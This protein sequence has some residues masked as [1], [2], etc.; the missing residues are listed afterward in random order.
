MNG[1]EQLLAAYLRLQP[2][3]VAR[4]LEA[5]PVEQANAV[6]DRVGVEIAAP[7]LGAMLPTSAARCVE[8]QPSADGARLLQRLGSQE[9]AAVLRHLAATA[10][11]A[12]LDS[13][14]PQWVVA[15][16]LLLSYP[17]N[18]VG[19]WVEP[20]VLT[21]PDD[22]GAGEARERIARSELVAQA[23]VYVLDR[24]RRIRGA[25]R[26]L[27]LLQVPNRKGLE[28]LLEPADSI[29]AREP[30]A[31]AQEHPVWERNSEA[32]VVNRDGEFIGVISYAD[33][34]K[35]SRQIARASGTNG[36]RDLAEVTELIA[37]G[38]GSLW[39]SL[40]ELV[41]RDRR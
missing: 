17:L 31:A 23:R 26:G 15:F 34:R 8:R 20:R 3:S 35:A 21:L 10:R 27:A 13:L 29:W 9:A 24:G 33:L 38:A 16:K 1:H 19:A 37:V 36:G 7:V 28:T 22:C 2:E 32:P 39:Q 30:L 6:L 40:G 14:G 25:I 11:E 12:V 4:Q 5:L 41:D 18:T